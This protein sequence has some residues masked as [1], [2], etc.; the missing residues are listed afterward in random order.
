MSLGCGGKCA[1]FFLVLINTLFLLL[2]IALLV[3]GIVMRVNAGVLNDTEI[4][5]LMNQVNLNGVTMAT[6]VTSLSLFS[7]CLGCFIIVVAGMGA[8]G[9]CCKVKCM[10]IV[11]AVIILLLL[12]AEIAIVALWA[13]MRNKVESIVTSEMTNAFKGYN[14]AS[15]KDE[16]TVGWNLLFIG[17]D[18]C[19]VVGPSND[20][21][22]FASTNWASSRGSD[23]IPY[24]CCKSSKSD[25]YASGSETSCTQSFQNYRST[26]C[27]KA[28]YNW[29]NQYSTAAI[30]IAAL[31]LAIEFFG[32]VFAF[33][34]CCDIDKEGTLV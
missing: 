3:I 32:M 15:A 14:G 2:G 24:S 9:A 7:I 12:L 19:G 33:V 25:N 21:D 5:K 1:M 4:L 22:E 34:L 18:C 10:L 11:Y 6:L 13:A 27:Y 17:M 30:V 31:I 8:F 20:L 23:K 26:G 28:I 16:K 29:F